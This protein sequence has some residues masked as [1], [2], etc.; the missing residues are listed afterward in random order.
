MSCIR[1]SFP[2]GPD[3][4]WQ[5]P[6]TSAPRPAGDRRPL[7]LGGA[8]LA[9]IIVVGALVFWLTRPPG[10]TADTA[11][12]AVGTTTPAQDSAAQQDLMRLVPRGY[13]AD[14]CRPAPLPDNARA[15]AS[16][17]PNTDAGGPLASTFTLAEDRA[18]LRS[19]FDRTVSSMQVRTCPGNIQSPGPWRR[20]ATPE[21]VAGT[22]VCGLRDTTPTV[23]WTTDDDLMVAVAES[24]SGGP[25]LDQLYTWWSMHS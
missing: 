21:K 1:A 16:C 3:P 19:L 12:T 11:D 20:N 2:T 22:L 8:A 14:S 7:L 25:R 4:R 18:G 6:D 15:A 10:D 23:A 5:F 17:G 24:G 13:P 9:V